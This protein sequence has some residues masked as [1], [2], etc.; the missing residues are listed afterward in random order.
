[1]LNFIE[2]NFAYFLAISIVLS[3]ICCFVV[4][5]AL[6]LAAILDELTE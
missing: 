3:W 1:M 6:I 4:A 5:E 2:R